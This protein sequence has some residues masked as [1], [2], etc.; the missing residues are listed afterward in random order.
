MDNRREKKVQASLPEGDSKSRGT[1]ERRE[2]GG[3]KIT[4]EIKE[5][6]LGNVSHWNDTV[7]Q[8]S[9]MVREEPEQGPHSWRLEETPQKLPEVGSMGTGIYKDGV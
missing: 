7:H 5:E 2:Y 6:E 4:T 9:S 8:T 3:E 1:V